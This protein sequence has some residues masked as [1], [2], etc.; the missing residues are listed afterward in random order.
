VVLL[1]TRAKDEACE[2]DYGK[3]LESNLGM[4]RRGS[5]M[6]NRGNHAKPGKP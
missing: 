1:D 6:A 4:N 2:W 5:A 3:R